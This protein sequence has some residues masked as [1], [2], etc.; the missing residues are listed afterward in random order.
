MNHTIDEKYTKGVRNIKMP[1]IDKENRT[2]R[3]YPDEGWHPVQ[4]QVQNIY[5]KLN[6]SFTPF[7]LDSVQRF[8]KKGYKRVLDVGC[9]YG[10]HS[11]YLAEHN[12]NVNSIDISSEAVEWLKDYTASKSMNNITVLKADINKLPFENDYFDVVICSS[13]LHHQCLKQIQNSISEIQRVLKQKGCLLFDFMSIE[14]DSFGVGEEIEEN[15]FVGSREGEEDI[16]HHYITVEELHRLFEN[17]T[18]II[19][20]KNEYHIFIDPE[21]RIVSRVFDALAYQ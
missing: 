21:N 10:K 6:I 3:D 1:L 14:D 15:T 13:V 20:Q 12:F 19:I 11:I 7:F 5:D 17:F 2:N 18:E 9:G 8:K 16:P 4:L